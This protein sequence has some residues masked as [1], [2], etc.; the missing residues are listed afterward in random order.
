MKCIH[1]NSME[2]TW[3]C[4]E[5]ETIN[6]LSSRKCDKCNCFASKSKELKANDWVCEKCQESNFQKRNQCRKCFCSK[7]IQSFQQSRKDCFSDKQ[8]KCAD[9]VTSSQISPSEPKFLNRISGYVGIGKN[10]ITIESLLDY[11]DN[12]DSIGH[13]S[14][15]KSFEECV[16][17]I[18]D[19]M[20][21]Q[22]PNFNLIINNYMIHIDRDLPKV[23]NLMQVFGD[24]ISFEQCSLVGEHTGA[25]FGKRPNYLRS[26]TIDWYLAHKRGES[27]VYISGG[28]QFVNTNILNRKGMF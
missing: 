27:N 13:L 15:F 8:E 22:Y 10:S 24:K 25:Y 5:C 23:E 18:Y 26:F 9:P 7:N 28:G 17:Y 2:R 19:E 11:K 16:K 12:N 3:T 14:N 4:P 1:E 6:N 20:Q 21:H